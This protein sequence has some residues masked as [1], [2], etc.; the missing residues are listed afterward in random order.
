MTNPT[1]YALAANYRITLHEG[2]KLTSLGR[3][4][5]WFRVES[6][7]N[8]Q[9]ILTSETYTTA[10]KRDLTANRVSVASGFEI[11]LETA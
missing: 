4:R 8:G 9:T 1:G 2:P 10:A 3:R 11:E 5:W 7:V 6:T